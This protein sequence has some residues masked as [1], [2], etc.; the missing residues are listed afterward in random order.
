MESS[1]TGDQF[2]HGI[3]YDE[4]WLTYNSSKNTQNKSRK[5][6]TW[7]PYNIGRSH[8][9]NDQC[10]YAG[11]WFSNSVYDLLRVWNMSYLINYK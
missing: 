9:W 8:Y 1:I 5:T 11:G 10:I 3:I 4:Y 6:H 2:N 7:L